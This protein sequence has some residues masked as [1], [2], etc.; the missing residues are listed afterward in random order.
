MRP[1]M[2]SKKNG[3]HWKWETRWAIE[4]LSKGRTGEGFD[5]LDK[6]RAIQ[7]IADNAGCLATIAEKQI[8][9]LKAQDLP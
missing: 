2:R 9:A 6:F 4:E 1:S 7:E 3:R 5:K 8:E